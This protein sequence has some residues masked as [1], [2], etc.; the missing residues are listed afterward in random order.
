[1]LDQNS[2]V[3]IPEAYSRQKLA[4][5]YRSISVSDDTVKL[6]RKYLK[7]MANLYGAIM[8]EKVYEII[9]SQN[10]E[11]LTKSEFAQYITVACHEQEYFHIISSDQYTEEDTETILNA[12]LIDVVL[13]ESDKKDYDM[14]RGAQINK[15]Y[16]IPEKNVL[17]RYYDPN[18]AEPTAQSKAMKNYLQETLG[19]SADVMKEFYGSLQR[20][21]RRMVYSADEVAKLF[22]EYKIPKLTNTEMEKFFELYTDMHNHSRMQCNNG[23]TPAEMEEMNPSKVESAESFVLGP[24][25]KKHL[26]NGTVGVADMIDSVLTMELPNEEVRRDLFKQIKEIVKETPNFKERTK[27]QQK[28]GRNDPCPCGS[29]KK[30]KKCCGK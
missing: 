14:V 11:L 13:L 7:A 15:P 24:N 26:Q 30:Y 10:P 16:Y 19:L 2:K 5:L 20:I 6:L 17:L 4:A 12:W 1:M 23:Y 3:S 18:Y 29:G 21:A 9:D 25:I 8:L 28:V 27:K 22:D